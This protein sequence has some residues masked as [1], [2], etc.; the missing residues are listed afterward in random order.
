MS[1]ASRLSDLATALAT[2]IKSLLASVGLL[3]G[4]TTTAKTSLVAAINEVNAKP[5]GGS[6]EVNTASNLGTSGVG[7]FAQKSGADLQFKKLIAGNAITFSTTA[8]DI[9][10]NVDDA[11]LGAQVDSAQTFALQAA[12]SE[13]A[14][15]NYASQAQDAVL[16]AQNAAAGN[17][18]NDNAVAANSGWSSQKINTVLGDYQK[19]SMG[20]T[21][22][23]N[24]VVGQLWIDTN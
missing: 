5:S 20:T 21:P 7:V 13:T 15:M 6:G 19:M 8:T 9:T 2:D 1:L 14:A 10:V 3:S 4:L 24:P 23:P 11:A 16:D 17:I 18:L 12:D 22:P